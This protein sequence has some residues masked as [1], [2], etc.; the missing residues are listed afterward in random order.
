[1]KDPRW[2]GGTYVALDEELDAV[3]Q[4]RRLKGENGRREVAKPKLLRGR[5]AQRRARPA[6]RRE[7]HTREHVVIRIDLR[8]QHYSVLSWRA[9]KICDV[10]KLR[11]SQPILLLCFADGKSL[12]FGSFL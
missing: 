4:T 7:W 3:G 1:M 6:R 10:C 2:R 12:R 8:I 5:A 11:F 9:L